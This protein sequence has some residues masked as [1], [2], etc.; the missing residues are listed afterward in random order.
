MLSLFLAIVVSAFIGIGYFMGQTAFVRRIIAFSVALIAALFITPPLLSLIG[1]PLMSII[2]PPFLRIMVVLALFI[3]VYLLTK[4]GLIKLSEKTH[5]LENE[6]VSH[7]AGGIVNG[8]LGLFTFLLL[9]LAYAFAVDF[10]VA[11]PIKSS[12]TY[13]MAMANQVAKGLANKIP[14]SIYISPNPQTTVAFQEQASPDDVNDAYDDYDDYK[15][16][17]LPTQRAKPVKPQQTV[18]NNINRPVSKP[19]T[20]NLTAEEPKQPFIFPEVNLND[21]EVE[22]LQEIVTDEIKN[23]LNESPD[24]LKR[25]LSD[26][27]TEEKGQELSAIIDDHIR[28]GRS[29]NN[30]MGKIEEIMGDPDNLSEEFKEALPD[31]LREMEVLDE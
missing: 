4:K 12:E 8:G 19:S 28:T 27:L 31:L 21:D 26:V 1:K 3:G 20:S 18:S 25:A 13:Y 10:K 6:K 7:I 22:A 17:K 23:L 30:L 9:L 2:P 5:F 24:E 11:S 16:V 14:K 15:H 29:I